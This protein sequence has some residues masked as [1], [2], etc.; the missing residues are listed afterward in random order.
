MNIRLKKLDTTQNGFA[1]RETTL[2]EEQLSLPLPPSMAD[3]Y[4]ANWDEEEEDAGATKLIHA[5]KEIW[6]FRGEAKV[7]S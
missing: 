1:R 5:V 2:R 4:G 6:M 7:E 3:R